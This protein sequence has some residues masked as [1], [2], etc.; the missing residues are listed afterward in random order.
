[1]HPEE[2][3]AIDLTNPSKGNQTAKKS[4]KLSAA[5]P[6]DDSAGAIS[7]RQL[8]GVSGGDVTRRF[9]RSTR[10]EFMI[11][12]SGIIIILEGGL[13]SARG[14]ETPST[15]VEVC[16]GGARTGQNTANDTNSSG[17]CWQEAGAGGGG[18]RE[19]GS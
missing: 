2:G 19:G 15:C 6:D 11:I 13:S 18:Y 14:A 1:M 16:L 8:S 10:G 4:S 9:I 3:V 12:I 17:R 5:R 7:L